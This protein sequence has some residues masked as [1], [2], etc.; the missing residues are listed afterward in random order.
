MALINRVLAFVPMV[1]SLV[2][3]TRAV[4]QTRA[5]TTP[6]RRF[7][8]LELKGTPA[9][10]GKKYGE[11]LREQIQKSVAIWKQNVQTTFK[12]DPDAFINKFVAE[13]NYIPAIEHWTPGLLDEV[14]GI[15][16]GSGIDFNTILAFQ[17]MDEYWVNAD[18]IAIEHCSVLGT[19]ATA[20][21]PN[22]IAQNM[23]LETFRDGFQ[24]I[25]HI[26]EPSGLQQF[27]LTQPGLIAFNGMNSA[28][29]GVNTNTVAQLAHAR[30]GLPVAFVVR[31]V[32]QRSTFPDV[33]S[34][35]KSVHHA[36]GQSY[37]IGASG[38]VAY[39]EAS[40]NKV[41]ELCG[42]QNG[43]FIYHTNHPIMNSDYSSEGARQM[44]NPEETD[45]SHTRYSAL[46]KRLSENPGSDAL[47]T[48]KATLR[49]HDSEQ[50]PICR[51]ANSRDG[52]FSYSSTIMV[53]TG[54]P[55]LIASPGPPDQYEYEVFRFGGTKPK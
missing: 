8:V 17:L 52:L 18:A 14:R 43:E 30:Q 16:E 9:E 38:R 46:Q 37:T 13:T 41:V 26:T 25:L 44:Q 6:E 10:R 23:D 21:H 55:R 32:L 29:V 36:S 50:H 19:A 11:Q 27:V 51:A 39:F 48:I 7:I 35:L 12:M 33:E 45:N 42:K 40:A 47:E 5:S 49:S 22:V 2:F 24:T 53:L 54:Q 1:A 15:S 34:F 4:P 20:L 3:T 28:G 31:G